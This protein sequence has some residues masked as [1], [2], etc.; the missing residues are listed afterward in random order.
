M[1]TELN[2]TEAKLALDNG[3]LL[4]DV[5]E[6][7]EVEEFS[8]EVPEMLVLPLSEFQ[9]RYGELPKDRQLIMACAGGGR[10]LYA[11]NFLVQHGYES[12]ANLDG[13]VFT[14]NALGLPVKKGGLGAEKSVTSCKL[15]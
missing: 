1:V 14:W 4:V 5:R 9:T 10:S 3:A 15:W 12:V 6:T 8:C 11:A 13:G 7:Y 2:P